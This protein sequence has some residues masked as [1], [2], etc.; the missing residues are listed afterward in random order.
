MSGAPKK[1]RPTYAI[2]F[3][4]FY[5]KDISVV[6]QGAHRYF[7]E[8]GD[9][10]LISVVGEDFQWVGHPREFDWSRLVGAHLIAHNYAFDGT[11][12]LY[13]QE[14]GVVPK[15]I[16]VED[17]D[18][19]ADMAAYF[20]APRNLKGAAEQMLGGY[21]EIDKAMRNY[22]R[23]R[24]WDEIDGEMKKRMEEYAL[25]DSV[26]CYKLW[27]LWGQ[28]WPDS[29][30]AVSRH[31]RRQMWRGFAID[32]VLLDQY[33][34]DIARKKWDAEQ[35]IPWADDAPILSR[36]AFNNECRL[37][38][39]DPPGS[40]AQDNPV[41][42]AW[43]EQ[44]SE[45]F[46]WVKAV[47]E[48]R[49]T[50][51]LL[52]KLESI[53]VRV[54]ED[55][56]V[57]TELKYWGAATTGR[58]SGT[59]GVNMQ[60]LPRGDMFGVDL[61]KLFVAG[62]GKKL[63]ISD[64]N[65]IEPRCTAY[66][67]KDAKLLEELETGQD[68]Y[69][70]YAKLNLGYSGDDLKNDDPNLRALAKVALLSSA[71]G[72]GWKKLME[73]SSALYG[74]DLSEDKAKDIVSGY[75]NSNSHVVS[76]WYDMHRRVKQ[77]SKLEGA[78]NKQGQK[79]LANKDGG[80]N[81]CWFD[82]ASGRSMFLFDCKNSAGSCVADPVKGDRKRLHWYGAKLFQNSVQATARDVM[83]DAILRVDAAGM[84]TVLHVHD[85]IIVEADM[86]ADVKDL[87]ELMAVTPEW[88]EGLPVAAEGFETNC[89][90]K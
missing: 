4:S 23:G 20:Q 79:L 64:L 76:M 59:G 89:Y 34:S 58:W 32:T 54:R 28:L 8:G 44:Q 29:E 21:E 22:M 75:R 57:S 73:T 84:E 88:A 6:T 19:T 17:G 15:E 53:K 68:V 90:T 78:S 55:K 40:L 46:P 16:V 67:T 50:N 80:V 12:L 77:T 74:L 35:L 14:Q 9:L 2:D 51:T 33:L 87:S 62:P 13:L 69:Q 7:R 48:W 41:A 1:D 85:E 24:R 70:A 83:R 31:T 43:M 5:S 82:L 86:D 61:R 47:N 42:M 10:Y 60:N 26:A 25:K 37:H 3:E 71:Y 65:A 30:K 27:A 49:R 11:A 52:S 39:I 36:K 18:C 38:G 45:R 81:D 66:I 56:R 72:T 63:L